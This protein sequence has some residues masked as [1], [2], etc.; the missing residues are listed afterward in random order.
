MSISPGTRIGRYEVRASLG[1][2]GMGEVF[3]ARDP[4]LGRDVA[5]KIIRDGE[6]SGD[7][8]RRFVQEAKAASAL[9]HPNV[10]HVYEV[11]S[12]EDVHFIAMELVEGETLRERLRRG[13]MP[14]DDVVQVGLQI[15]GGLAAAHAAQIVHRDIKPENVIIRPDGYVKI[16]DFGLAK[17]RESRGDDEATILKTQAGMTVGTLGYMA[18]EQLSGGDVTP[19]ADVF[20]LG[21]VLYEMV[22]GTRAFPGSNAREI[23]TSILTKTP[24]PLSL[25]RHDVPPKLEGVIAR[26]LAR[27]PA[28]RYATA[29]EI[30][31]EL[32][33]ISREAMIAGAAPSSVGRDLLWKAAAAVALAVILATAGWWMYRQRQE[34]VARDLIAAAEERLGERDYAQAYEKAIAAA[35]IVPGHRRLHELL[36]LTSEEAV[37][38]SDPRGATVFLQ[39]IDG[40]GRTAAGTTPLTIPR[41][42]HGNY[43]VTFE[44]EGYLPA[45]RPLTTKPLLHGGDSI[46]MKPAPI[47]VRLFRNGEL[48]GGMV[49]VRGGQYQLTGWSRPSDRTVELDDFLIDRYEVSNR[50]FEEFVRAGGYRRAELWKDPF[51][52][53]GKTLSFSEAMGRFR[54]T[55]GLAGP[56]H[57]VR[58]APPAGLEN[59]PVTNV[60]W[61]EAAAFAAWKGKKLP[62][63]YQW[64]RAARDPVAHPT[65]TALGTPF[66]WGVVTQGDDVTDR[67]NFVGE[68]TVPVDSMP[69]GISPWGAHHMAGNVAE[70]CRNPKKPGFTVRG[71]AWNDAVYAF[72]ATGAFPSFYSSSTLGFRCVKEIGGSTADQGAFALATSTKAPEFHPVGHEEFEE[73]R[74]RYDYAPQPLQARVVERIDRPAWAIERIEY[75]S[76]GKRVPAYLFLPKGYEPPY[77]VIQFSPGSDVSSGWRRL[78]A[79][80]EIWLGGAIR[81]GRAAFAVIGQGYLGRPREMTLPDSRSP[82]YADYMITQVTEL[83]RG[84]DYLETR[85][86]VDSARLAFFAISAGAAE[87]VLLAALE[88]RYQS[89]MLMGSSLRERE[90]GVTAAASRIN[91]APRMGGR[92]L[93]F[94]GRYDETAPWETDG[95]ALFDQLPEPK[96]VEFFEGGHV[97]PSNVL[98]P[99]MQAWLDETLGPVK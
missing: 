77:Q 87:G 68:G 56:R 98:I 88:N 79:A 65:A 39:R 7:R 96:R 78:D 2:G 64:E 59:H 22:S 55:T 43:V 45:S 75:T 32:R 23:I 85:P 69:F 48:E 74:R 5:I 72:G 91:F 71:G 44:R 83:R 24:E 53:G 34:A 50:D 31:E 89:V 38:D 11:G 10:A 4:S 17:L 27:D 42:P 80:I 9:S 21:V 84:L 95:R 47:Q 76:G 97:A 86:D 33:Q 13:P 61:Y 90:K 66:P 73:I 12:F 94:H 40:E 52:D 82:E 18:P 28:E 63:I 26:A 92:K 19:A 70:W 60:T 93:V 29:E 25:R 99:T 20:S 54:D 57:W 37:F 30:I 14:L 49:H 51:V 15:A 6:R 1:A 3:R 46:G 62:T 81:A 58:G 36:A 35:A 41:L 16:L 8:V 67:A